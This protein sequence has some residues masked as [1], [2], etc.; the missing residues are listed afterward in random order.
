MLQGKQIPPPLIPDLQNIPKPTRHH[1]QCRTS[2]AFQKRIG[3]PSRRQSHPHRRKGISQE[4]ARHQPRAYHR[5]LLPGEHFDKFSHRPVSTAL[6]PPTRRSRDPLAIPGPYPPHLP[7]DKKTDRSLRQ[8]VHRH[9][10]RLHRSHTHP[11]ATGGQQLAPQLL[12][13]GIAAKA[14]RESSPC[15]R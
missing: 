12:P 2:L 13:R 15:I 8:S 4:S 7:S 1:Q 10:S 14:I 6:Q 5:C 9:P 11:Q 3:R